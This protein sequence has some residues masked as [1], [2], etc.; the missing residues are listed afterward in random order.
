[1][2]EQE[3]AQKP[4]SFQDFS[5]MVKAKYPDYKDVDDLTLAQKMVEKYPEYKDQVQFDQ[6]EQSSTGS[7]QLANAGTEQPLTYMQKELRQKFPENYTDEP[8][9]AKNNSTEQP[10]EEQS[11]VVKLGSVV[12]NEFMTGLNQLNSWAAD[13]P[14]FIYDLAGA[15]FRA[16]GLNV[17]TS[18]DFKDTPLSNI[19]DFY[20]TNSKA[21]ESKVMAI[22]PSRDKGI[23]GAFEQGDIKG[24][25]LNL[26]G[27][28]AESAPSSIAMMLA[29][30]ATM[31][32]IL[33]GA[34]VFGAGKAQ[35]IDEN[36]PEMNYDK[37]R[38]IAAI[39]GTFEGVFETYLGS[40]AVAKSLAGIIKKEGKDI[41]QQQ[42]KSSFR[43][44]INKMLTEN[45]WLA[46]LGEGFEEVGTQLAQNAVD[47]YSGYKPNLS[48][49]DGVGDSFAAGFGM[50]GIHGAV[51]GLAKKAME[52]KQH[53]SESSQQPIQS[54][55]V[56]ETPQLTVDPRQTK[57]A[58]IRQ[59]AD[60]IKSKK[61]GKIQEVEIITPRE[62][63]N[64][65]GLVVG[66]F[67]G[68]DGKT[69]YRVKDKNKS[70]TFYNVSEL[71]V[72]QPKET[73]VDEFVNNQLGVYDQT[74]QKKQLAAN[75]QMIDA[76]GRLL[77]RTNDPNSITDDGEFWLDENE[78][79]I[80]VP[81]E[82]I[83]AWEQA[84]QSKPESEANIISE[85]YGNTTITGT[86]D[87]AGNILVSEPASIDQANALKEQVEK[88][89][90]GNATVQAEL[91]PNED[92]TA[93]QQFK[94]SVIPVQANTINTSGKTS[95]RKIITQN[96]NNT[97]IDLAENEGYDEVVP[98]DKVP[99][100]K[101]LPIL[102]KKFKDHPKYELVVDKAEVEIPGKT[103]KGE[104]KWD[105]DIVEPPTKR[106]EIKS[107]KIVPKEVVAKQKAEAQL[108]TKEQKQADTNNPFDALFENT[109]SSQ[110]IKTSNEFSF[111]RFRITP[112][113]EE[114][115][116]KIDELQS[117]APSAAPVILVQ[118]VDE[119]PAEIKNH[120]LFSLGI[121]GVW[122]NDKVY[123]MADKIKSI[124]HLV[125]IWIHEN[126]VHNGLRNILPANER[127]L[128]M[129][130]VYDS[131]R[132]IAEI[133][134]EIK[135]L[136][137]WVNREYAGT[138]KQ[139]RG[140]ELLASLS[141]KIVSREDLNPEVKYIWNE[142]IKYLRDLL[143]KLYN[144]NGSLLTEG[145]LI[146]I[147]HVSVQS[148]FQKMSIP[149]VVREEA[150]A[151]AKENN[152]TLMEAKEALEDNIRIRPMEGTRLTFDQDGF[153][154][155][156]EPSRPMK[157]IQD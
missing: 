52:E 34:A 40:G 78:Q 62:T 37:G 103:I 31:P 117:I 124:D 140:E 146:E 83:A 104:T 149:V 131:F 81:N 27:S 74:E 39:N 130:Q 45:P 12:G 82:E 86:K 53:G 102:E 46:P 44:G 32:T 69:I 1:M 84:K 157:R 126:G 116:S 22:N 68:K 80:E 128:L 152:V 93:P 65:P 92:A 106:V 51:I 57:E 110:N 48:L 142:T 141:E 138:T 73:S 60:E 150:E 33:G 66:S 121:Y 119:L 91:I 4:V 61:S 20:K 89:T 67:V 5:S 88:S 95:E 49:M 70:N 50:G 24:G 154:T 41:A 63:D 15:P 35:E 120:S 11:F 134:P 96:F 16:V 108:K 85:R 123:V 109:N 156:S 107:I 56:S 111:N 153:W 118:S 94:L 127:N 98:T 112:T 71:E 125:A 8:V 155:G 38:V 14:G 105:D 19:S 10:Q 115:Q 97:A 64:T 30:G 26:A 47:K 42:I 87:E 55:P 147:I 25:F 122:Y 54:G 101:A 58:E 132:K 145:Q 136:F 13:A 143:S 7:P 100:E 43:E 3:I 29:G 36:S 79:G 139:V 137:D 129:V 99:L 28:I 135:E 75:N 113:V 23:I 9:V 144:F 18:K 2:T 148:N 90:G 77:T 59:Y 17:P 151:Y 114:M 76:Q 21:Y 133:K 6:P 72:T